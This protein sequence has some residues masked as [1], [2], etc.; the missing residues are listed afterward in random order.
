MAVDPET[1]KSRVERE[2]ECIRDARVLRHIRELLVEPEVVFRAWDYGEP[3]EKFPCWAVLKHTRSETGIAYCEYGFGPRNPWGLV[4]L[5]ASENRGS[6]GMDSE[7]FTCFLDAYFDSVIA[8][9]LPVWRVF[10]RAGSWPG[11]AVTEEGSWESAWEYVQRFR[12]EDPASEYE[13]H[14]GFTHERRS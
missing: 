8:T 3:G 10:K 7:W 11:E 14:H 4:S 1:L 13:V 6:M 9:E 12:Q 2:L 5:E